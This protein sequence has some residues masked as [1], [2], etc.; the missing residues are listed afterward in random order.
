MSYTPGRE[1]IPGSWEE[2]FF[3]IYS[4]LHVGFL[5]TFLLFKKYIKFFYSS[6]KYF[7]RKLT[8]PSSLTDNITVKNNSSLAVIGVGYG[9]TGTFSLSLALNEIGFPSLHTQHLY[10]YQNQEI[11]DMLLREVFIPSLTAKKVIM[12][13]P[14]FDLIAS[15]GFKAITDFPVALYFEEI[16]ELYPN[17][18][19]IL[20][21]RENSEV[22]FRSWDT[23][24]K[25][26]TQPTRFGYFVPE[27]RNLGYYLRWLFSII[28]D[29]ESY[30]T[31]PFP[32][33]NQ[34][35]K[36]AI[37]SYES[38]NKRVREIVPPDRLLEYNVKDG[39]SPLCD[40][41]EIEICPT[42]PFPKSNSA[43]SVQIQAISSIIFPLTL[44]LVIIFSL[45][46]CIFK[47]KTGKTVAAWFA[48]KKK[49][50]VKASLGSDMNFY[51]KNH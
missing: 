11:F 6:L 4:G 9:R 37:A 47:R 18:K 17:T 23:L 2:F 36:A 31:V 8:V 38:H 15:K 20:T 22:W 51:K 43:R 12:G 41:L 10:E 46:S 42:T 27:V 7:V 26:I 35:K 39:W 29:D 48:A 40:F 45:F 28:N 13:K 5:H 34:N 1:L 50:L 32:L 30:L 25:S 14:D 21:A 44:T 33:P 3:E 24:T 19:F 16:A 49:N